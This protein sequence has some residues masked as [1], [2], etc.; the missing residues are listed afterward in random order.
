VPVT[1]L[2]DLTFGVMLIAFAAIGVLLASRRPE[3]PIGWLLVICPVFLSYTGAARGWYVHTSY[4]DHGSLPLADG[5]MWLAN[6]AWIPGYMPLLTFVL[7]LFPDGRTASPRWRPVV[8]LGLLAMGTLVLGYSFAPG[9]LEDY[10][11]VVN[12]L[13]A[14]GLAGDVAEVFLGLGF[15]LFA[16]AALLSMASLVVRFRRSV[17]VERQQLKWMAAAAALVVAAWFVNAVLDQVFDAN[18]AFLMPIVLL[19]LPVAA[20][21]AVLRYRLYDLELVVNRTLVYATLTA[22][23]AGA[24]I[25]MVLLLQL[26]LSPGSD[27]AIAGSTLAVAALFRP[28]R[29]R[30]QE[31][32]DRRFYRRKYD[33]AHTI[34]AFSA[35]LRDQVELDSLSTELRSTVSET[36]QPAHVSLW[37]RPEAGR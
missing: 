24:Y 20:A 19:S 15:P 14:S 17:G 5:L 4:A 29:T 31:L 8:W 28:A 23:L 22:I 35:R 25:G 6:W 18:S 2:G 27:L 10:E 32:V 26:V 12:P 34:E 36:M 30:I 21:V 9:P 3:N 11:R 1:G 16:L 37:L 7:L 33:A 13:G